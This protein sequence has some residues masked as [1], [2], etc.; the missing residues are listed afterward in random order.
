[1]EKDNEKMGKESFDKWFHVKDYADLAGESVK[2]VFTGN[3]FRK[4][5]V[6]SLVP[7]FAL[8][9]IFLFC[10]IALRYACEEKVGEITKAELRL[11]DVKFDALTRSS[12][13]LK[14]KRQTYIL[15]LVEKQDEA[16]RPSTTPP[17]ALKK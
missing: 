5:S 9:V 15:Q 12:E 7:L 2:D 4:E 6:T 17:Y 16:L 3:I 14:H 8:V 10:H 13:L 1:M 11:V